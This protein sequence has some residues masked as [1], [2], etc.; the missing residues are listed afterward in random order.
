MTPEA[1]LLAGHHDV[2]TIPAPATVSNGEILKLA[3]K[4]CGVV[5]GL[6][7]GIVASGD[8]ISVAVSGPIRV[9]AASAK[10]ISAGGLVTWDISANSA[11]P[12]GDG[13]IA[14]GDPVVGPAIVAKTSGQLHFDVDL[15]AQ[16]GT[17][18]S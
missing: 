18:A 15:N 11:L 17:V 5:L 1:K 6:N 4:R 13:S 8:L 9:K 2:I 12:A 16:E 14:A 10:T 7:S 3:D